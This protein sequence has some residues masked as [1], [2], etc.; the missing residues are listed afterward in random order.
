MKKIV[1]TTLFAGCF[2]ASSVMAE[3]A[4]FTAGTFDFGV[5][6]A[7]GAARSSIK[8]SGFKKKTSGLLG[9]SLCTKYNVSDNFGLGLELFYNAM[10]YKRSITVDV[11]GGKGN[12]EVK[13]TGLYGALLTLHFSPSENWSFLLGAGINKRSQLDFKTYGVDGKLVEF[14]KEKAK[15]SPMIKIGAAYHMNKNLALGIEA[16]SSHQKF[17]DDIKIRTYTIAATLAYTF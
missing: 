7:A 13:T 9:L 11:N 10:K 15:I 17:D 12:H 2:V 4:A 1:L 14:S 16:S 6:V 3:G 5:K 8:D